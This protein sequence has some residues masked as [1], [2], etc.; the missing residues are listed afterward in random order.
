MGP[1]PLIE[2]AF[3]RDGIGRYAG[4]ET[5]GK[6]ESHGPLPRLLPTSLGVSVPKDVWEQSKK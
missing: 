6:S 2:L 1:I 3:Q 5:K 4:I